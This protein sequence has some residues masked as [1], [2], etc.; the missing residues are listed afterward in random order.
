MFHIL[1][2]S[3]HRQGALDVA[4]IRAGLEHGGPSGARGVLRAAPGAAGEVFPRRDQAGQSEGGG[5]GVWCAP[6][7][8][9]RNQCDWKKN[10]YVNR[11]NWRDKYVKRLEFFMNHGV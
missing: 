3:G 9:E 1:C 8:S 5:A 7:H 6:A 4:A 10:N 11:V 2:S